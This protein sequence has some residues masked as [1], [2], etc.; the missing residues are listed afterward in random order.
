MNHEGS[1]DQAIRLV[2]L[3]KKGGADAAKFQS[4]K[5]ENL[6]SCDSPSY[7]DTSKEVTR[8]QYELFKKY[9]CFGAYEYEKLAKHCRRVGIDFL[10]TPFD[11]SAVEILD[12]LVSVFKV[13]SADLTNTPLLRKVASKGKPVLLAT[14]ASHKPEIDEAL[15][16]LRRAGCTQ[17]CLL[18]CILN[19]PTDNQNAHLRMIEGLRTAYPECVIGY[20]DHTLPDHSMTSLVAAHL[21]GAM[22]LE[23]H[24]THDKTLPGNDHYHAMDVNDLRNLRQQL[25]RIRLLIGQKAEK[26]AIPS[27]E[28]ARLNARRSIVVRKNLSAGHCIG[29]EDIICKRPGMGISPLF[30]DKVLGQKTIRSLQADQPLNW[31]DLDKLPFQP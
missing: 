20:S 23:K 2:D 19:Y 27:E 8:S 14:G 9:D 18:H 24:F 15:K 28:P 26:I 21:L 4:Y 16:T 31:N 1:L 12:P 5:A 30:W 13:A 10:S 7:W 25:D 22:V 11:D 29:P 17:I 6:A 3:A